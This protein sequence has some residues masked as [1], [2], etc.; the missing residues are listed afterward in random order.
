[1]NK[2]T[3]LEYLH[4]SND[5]LHVIVILLLAW[6]LLGL[7]RKL[8]RLFRDYMNNRAD[9]AED[10]RRIETLAR[11]FRYI[12]T[13]VISLVAGML[14]L[15]EIGISIAPILGA[16]GVV[17]LAVGFGAQSLIK[18]YFNGFF[19]LL[20]NQIRQGDVIEVCEKIGVVEDITLRYV[21][22]RDNEGSVHYVP[23]GQI[24][25]VTNKSRDY[26]YALIDIGV[27]YREDMAEVGQVVVEVGRAMRAEA[28]I[29][30][31]ILDDIEVQGVQELADSAVILRCRIKTVALDQWNVRRAFL[32]RIKQAFDARGIEIPY[33][34]LTLYAGQDKQG[35]SPAFPLLN[36]RTSVKQNPID[37]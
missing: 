14:V 22:L 10:K 33:P 19:L 18:D 36:A 8:I 20:E 31:S 29:S 34:H 25:I 21:C 11:V 4:L 23:N 32:G 24:S 27:A 26:A 12:S 35:R 16:A 30:A 15:S 6:L 17:G 1:M 3:L 13:V 37:G 9:T 28:G 2:Q 7:S 5:L